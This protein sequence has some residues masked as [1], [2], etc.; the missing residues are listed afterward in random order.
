MLCGAGEGLETAGSAPTLEEGDTD[1]MAQADRARQK[2]FARLDTYLDENGGINDPQKA[3]GVMRSG[4]GWSPSSSI[5]Y[6]CL[7]G[8]HCC[9]SWLLTPSMRFLGRSA[10]AVTWVHMCLL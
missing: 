6:P 10:P 5:A 9:L 7:R 3:G 1:S 8:R 2:A 4:L